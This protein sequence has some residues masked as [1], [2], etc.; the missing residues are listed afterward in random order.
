MKCV[1]TSGWVRSYVWS[2]E[3][4]PAIGVGELNDIRNGVAMRAIGNGVVDPQRIDRHKCLTTTRA[5]EMFIL[6]GNTKSGERG[7]G[8]AMRT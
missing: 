3:D 1:I 5:G 2:I 8:V 4:G 6:E 7:K